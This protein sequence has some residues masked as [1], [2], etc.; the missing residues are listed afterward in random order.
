MEFLLAL[1]F[2]LVK[3]NISEMYYTTALFA[4]FN[5]YVDLKCH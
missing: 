5:F 4:V 1:Y 3:R 2:K